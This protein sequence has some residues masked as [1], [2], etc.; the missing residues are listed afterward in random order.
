M[1]DLAPD[2]GDARHFRFA[3]EPPVIRFGADATDGLAA[4]LEALD[5]ERALVV[6]GRSVGAS[7]AVMDPVRRGL[8]GSLA[9]VFAET[10]PQKRLATA[11]RGAREYSAADADAV[12]AV[13][14]GSSLDVA[15]A[16]S[17]VLAKDAD[18][19]EIGREF[20]ATGTITPDSDGLPPLV[21]VPTTLA[22]ADLSGVG[23]LSA[24][25][26]GGLV[27]EPVRGGLADPR[28]LPR[29][30]VYDPAVAATTP[31]ETLAASAMNGFDKGIET[32][33]A[34]TATPV[35]DATASRGLRLLVESLP[36]LGDD[37][38]AAEDL[39]PVLRGIVLVQYGISRPAESTLSIVHAFGHGLTSGYDV[40]QGAA[41]AVVAPHVLEYLFE[42]VD[43]RRETLADAMGV[44][45]AADPAAAVVDRVREI[46]DALGLPAE[47][48]AVAGPAPAEFHDVAE[49]ILAD[50]L[51]A[52]APPGL[53][54]SVGDVREVL[55]AAY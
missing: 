33:Y 54:P 50:G 11:V 4:E 31:R 24:V 12:V 13:G 36:A 9:G 18:P 7:A 38:V 6:C 5:R 42:E 35:T 41:H 10:T 2:G 34:S 3:Y 44:G 43:G 19:E 30:A 51:M 17:V 47:L 48:R 37:P 45:D 8:G 32:L 28:L 53:D 27:D 55:E 25:P 26:A 16:V 52:Y 40:Q 49:T 1:N 29:A 14:G 21:V 22:G 46:R 15:R 20:A 39:A 23:G